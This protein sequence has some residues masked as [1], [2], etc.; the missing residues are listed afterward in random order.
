MAVV[1]LTSSILTVCISSNKGTPVAIPDEELRR[2]IREA[3]DKEVGN[4]KITVEGL[5]K[6]TELHCQVETTETLFRGTQ[7]SH[8]PIRDLSGV[9]YCVN[10]TYLNLERNEISDLLPISNLA[11]LTKLNL[12][13]DQIRDISPLSNLTSLTMLSLEA[14]N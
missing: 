13:G 3:L 5:A 2:C 10:L 14:R 1:L 7:L 11:K 9:E 4:K 12:Y 6:I 8:E